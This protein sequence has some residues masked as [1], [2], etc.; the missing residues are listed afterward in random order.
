[1]IGPTAILEPLAPSLQ[2]TIRE[3]AGSDFDL[4]FPELYRELYKHKVDCIL[5][6]FYNAR[7]KGP[8]V[9]DQSQGTG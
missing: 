2:A 7:Q 8:S 1:M 4:R 5:Q 3:I 6:S 9:H